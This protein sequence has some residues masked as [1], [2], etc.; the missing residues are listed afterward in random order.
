MRHN[1][2][3]RIDINE[4]THFTPKQHDASQAVKLFK[5]VLY[6]GAMG[7]GK[8]YWLRWQLVIL[9]LGFAARGH[10]HVTVGLF[11]ETYDTLESRHIS[12]LKLEFPSWLG[13]YNASDHTFVLKEIYGGGVIAFRNLDDVSKYQSSE[14][15]VIAVDELTKNKEVAFMYLRT[16]LRW[17]GIDDTKFIAATNPGGAG[18]AW[19][20]KLWIDKQFPPYEK[21]SARFTYIRALVSDNPYISD[22]YKTD[23]ESLPDDQRRAFLDGDW[24]VFEGQYFP[25]FNRD[26]HTC[27]PREIPYKAMIF[28]AVDYGYT[29]PSAALWCYMDSEGVVYVYRELYRKGLTYVELAKTISEMTPVS[30]DVRYWVVDPSLQNR[31]GETGL[32]GI[33]IMQR[34]YR[35]ARGKTI[36]IRLA[37]NDRLTGW[38]MVRTFLKKIPMGETSGARLRI[39]TACPELIRTL[40]ALMHD[41]ERP[42]DLDTRGEDHAAD[43]LRYGLMSEPPR[44][45]S[46]VIRL[47]TFDS[48][49]TRMLD[50]PGSPYH[51]EKPNIVDDFR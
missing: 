33:D 34:A 22:S 18:H 7:G 41:T 49:L 30:E 2:G 11:C 37:N 36:F 21:E 28:V 48:R 46:T 45:H 1:Q 38:N 43:A 14:F 16:R 5:F 40:P 24:D 47:P 6:G 8:S 19:V 51:P 9:L 20:K 31:S 27:E 17:P 35:E 4:I 15:A 39:S 32:S 10:R 42:E 3:D 29:A 50:N 12:K 25:E 23:L 26:L 13:K 44:T